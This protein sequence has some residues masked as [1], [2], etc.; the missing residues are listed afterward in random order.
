[1]KMLNIA[2]KNIYL[3]F[4]RLI[5]TKVSKFDYLYLVSRIIFKLK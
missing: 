1:M 2:K 5:Y 4:K 3:I